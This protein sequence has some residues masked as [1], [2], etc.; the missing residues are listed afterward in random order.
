MSKRRKLYKNYSSFDKLFEEKIYV[1]RAPGSN[2]E[3][4]NTS[5]KGATVIEG[6]LRDVLNIIL[7]LIMPVKVRI[8]AWG[9]IGG[10]WIEFCYEGSA[11]TLGELIEFYVNTRTPARIR[12]DGV[13]NKPTSIP[14]NSLNV[15]IITKR[16]QGLR[17]T[18][19]LGYNW[20]L[21]PWYFWTRDVH[22]TRRYGKDN[23]IYIEHNDDKVL[24]NFYN[25]IINGRGVNY[26]IRSVIVEPY[27]YYLKLKKYNSKVLN[28]LMN[29]ESYVKLSTSEYKPIAHIWNISNNIVPG[30]DLEFIKVGTILKKTEEKYL[31]SGST[32]KIRK[33]T[34][35]KPC[36]VVLYNDKSVLSECP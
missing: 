23:A 14:I 27:S 18:L 1:R 26:E 12:Y 35:E 11:E 10:T 24:D 29:G 19:R 15:T 30:G 5:M 4:R 20:L 9:N 2:V 36:C 25:A 3:V 17:V 28:E 13:V 31:E 22:S 34:I 7:S 32:G 6:S 21:S 8:D 16:I 33:K